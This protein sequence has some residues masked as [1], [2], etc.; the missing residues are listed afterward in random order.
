MYCCRLWPTFLEPASATEIS[1]VSAA[2]AV[3]PKRAKHSEA[4]T[5]AS[6]CLHGIGGHSA[7][8]CEAE[9]EQGVIDTLADLSGAL[10]PVRGG[11]RRLHFRYAT[12]GIT[13]DRT[14]P[15][16]SVC[17]ARRSLSTRRSFTRR[18]VGEGGSLAFTFCSRT[19]RLFRIITILW[20]N[21]S[22]PPRSPRR[23][24]RVN[25]FRLKRTVAGF[26]AKGEARRQ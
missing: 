13:P 24:G 12:V 19:R 11:L 22:S 14:C 5:S 21:V 20:K 3:D 10:Q 15:R 2:E 23:P 9:A 18:L 7:R 16:R 1:S 6:D 8:L 25:L 26:D 17:L 4:V